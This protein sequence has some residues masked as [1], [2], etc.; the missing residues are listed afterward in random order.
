MN[1][2]FQDLR[3]AMRSLR[4]SPGFT[5]AAV[6][7]LALGIGANTAIFS[8]VNAVLLRPLPYHEP[9]Q[10][11]R[12]YESGFQEGRFSLSYPL[13][14]D[15]RGMR[16][17]FSGVA[18]FYRE[19]FNFTGR[20]DPRE[21]SA[22]LADPE[23]FGLLGATPVLGRTFSAEETRAR[24]VVLSHGLWSG[25]FGSDPGVIGRT[26]TLDGVPYN[27]IGVMP[28]S[29]RFPD[30]DAELWAPVGVVFLTAPEIETAREQRFFGTVARIAPGVTPERVA[31]DL[32]V[33]A[34]RIDALAAS[35]PGRREM[36]VIVGGGGPPPGA[37]AGGSAQ[38]S[39]GPPQTQL[40]AVPLREEVVGN[41]R[42][43]LYVLFGTVALVLLIACAN[44]AN[45][46]VARA[47]ARRKEI[48][49]RQALGAGRGRIA[50]QLLTESVLLSVIAG[51]LG[52]CLGYWGV[53]LLLATWPEA[54]P[55]V[56]DVTLDWRV[57]G[58]TAG[59]SVLTGIGFGAIPAIRASNPAIEE[60]LREEGGSTGGG[61]RRQRVQRALV[62][63]QIAIAMVLLVGAGLLV[64][65]FVRLLQVDPGYDTRNVLA[66]RIRPT[67]TRYE[68]PTAKSTLLHGIMDDLAARQGVSSVTLSRTLPLS[69]SMMMMGLP[70]RTI[71]PDDPDEFLPVG[72]RIV[73]SE[74]FKAMRIS[75]VEGRA[76]ESG[77]REG[78]P[79]V[80]VVNSRL[81]KRLWPEQSAIGQHLPLQFPGGPPHEATVVGIVGDIHYAGLSDEI[82]PELYVPI[83]QTPDPG[84]QT[85]VVARVERNPLAL[86][87]AVREAVRRIDPDQPVAELVSLEEMVG[88]STAAR[89]FNMSL[90]SAF[91]ALAFGLALIG[92]YGVTAYSVSQRTH[93][94][95]IRVAL[96]ADHGDVI[97]LVLGEGLWLAGLGTLVGLALASTTAR[98]LS[99]MLFGTTVTDAVTFLT[100][101]TLLVVATLFAT[102]LPAHRAARV[103][104][105]TALRS[106]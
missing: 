53:D 66:V 24:V 6:L 102:W 34:R 90:I 100:S 41:V 15:L 70:A 98:V 32:S 18:A 77:D 26:V 62:T 19:Q 103:D 99:S 91:A 47:N 86:A 105:L 8:V 49:I 88:R 52:I 75:V 29:F 76:F 35:N 23:L 83:E 69:G 78:A 42:P 71:H 13:V 82:Q 1:T 57:L 79:S 58:F 37:P 9:E 46:L 25:T 10:L 56:R 45:L 43:T 80:V 89:R 64:R 84:D 2:L 3:H 44:A 106:E 87:G 104:P 94:I 21:V 4:H 72:M 20:G 74:Y 40:V 50:R 31:G 92:I 96:G 67:P 85:W 7:T 5:A 12:L 81:A 17:T 101:A 38:V 73:G 16:Q 68:N 61:R 36:R 59:I 54:L 63:A 22:V 97:R 30:E 33:L 55:R 95:G 93:E 51:S 28:A 65:S 11:V 27:V 48:V 39:S 14:G 60:A